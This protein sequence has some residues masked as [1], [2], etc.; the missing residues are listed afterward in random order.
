MFK[1]IILPF[2]VI[3][4]LGITAFSITS[5]DNSTNDNDN[6]EMEDKTSEEVLAFEPFVVL[7]LFTSQG[8]SSCPSADLL[9]NKAKK[10]YQDKVFALSYHVD[11]WNY[12][13]WDDPYSKASYAKKQRAYNIKFKNRSNYTPQLVVNGERHFVG[14]NSAKVTNSVTE[15]LKQKAAN[16][17][18]LA[19]IAT[20][21]RKV[22]FNYE[23][24]G[25]L[26]DKNLKVVLVLD[27]RVTEVKRGEN[28]NRTLTNSNIVVAEHFIAKDI[29]KGS[30]SIAIP[31]LVEQ[32]EKVHIMVL[33]EDKAYD[34]TGASKAVVRE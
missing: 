24:L 6:R 28:R 18:V 31:S 25:D 11:Y 3:V 1:K 22:I 10:Q 23:T 15:G 19:N 30:A 34:I 9:L 20:K 8:C 32:G 17:V 26:T 16:K 4:S 7:E 33:V 12:I 21:D 27:E 13:G 14:S 5:N 29:R 2:V